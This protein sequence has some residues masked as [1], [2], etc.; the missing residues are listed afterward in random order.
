[1]CYSGGEKGLHRA[2]LASL[3]SLLVALG[4]D[5]VLFEPLLARCVGSDLNP[6]LSPNLNPPG[7]SDLI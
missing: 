1:M 6:T 7:A 3:S 2:A 4:D 5:F